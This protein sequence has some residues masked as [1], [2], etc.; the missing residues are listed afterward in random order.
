[1]KFKC[2]HCEQPV[3]P[4]RLFTETK[5]KCKSCGAKYIQL[6]VREIKEDV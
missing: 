5:F 1:M 3:T 4:P 6:V 2:N